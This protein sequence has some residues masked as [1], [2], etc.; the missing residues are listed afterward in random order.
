MHYSQSFFRKLLLIHGEKAI[1]NQCC[2]SVS[3]CFRSEILRWIPKERS[4]GVSAFLTGD[5]E[6]ERSHTQTRFT[7]EITDTHANERERV[8]CVLP[9]MRT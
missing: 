1:A 8:A 4:E 9:H 7:A 6:L 5:R 2:G 3:A